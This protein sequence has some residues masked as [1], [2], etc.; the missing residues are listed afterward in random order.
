MSS[1]NGTPFPLSIPSLS[2]MSNQRLVQRTGHSRKTNRKGKGE[3][4]LWEDSVGYHG[5][6]VSS[7]SGTS[8]LLSFLVPA[9]E[10]TSIKDTQPAHRR[11]WSGLSFCLSSSYSFSFS[12]PHQAKLKGKG[13]RRQ[14]KETD[15]EMSWPQPIKDISTRRWA[16]MSAACRPGPGLYHPQLPFGKLSTV[17]FFS[18]IKRP[19]GGEDPGQYLLQTCS[20]L[21]SG[22]VLY[23]SVFSHQYSPRDREREYP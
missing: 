18:F 2:A 10:D 1:L 15:Q 21:R 13:E 11:D 8:S 16:N 6:L 23:P 12:K 17:S 3:V 20:S 5:R 14:T 7:L 22:R 4:P 9:R 19:L